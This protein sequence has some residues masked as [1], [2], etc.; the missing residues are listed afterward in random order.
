MTGWKK[1]AGDKLEKSEI[2][3]VGEMNCTHVDFPA[4]IATQRQ[5]GGDPDHS[6]EL[7]A[8][9]LR[10]WRRFPAH[11]AGGGVGGPSISQAAAGGPSPAP[12]AGTPPPP[13]RKAPGTSAHRDPPQAREDPWIRPLPFARPEPPSLPGGACDGEM[14][15]A[16][17]AAA[18]YGGTLAADRLRPLLPQA[19]WSRCAVLLLRWHRDRRPASRARPLPAAGRLGPGAG[20]ENPGARA[21]RRG[22]PERIGARCRRRCRYYDYHPVGDSA[23][24][25][26]QGC[27]GAGPHGSCWSFPGTPRARKGLWTSWKGLGCS[28][29]QDCGMCGLLAPGWHPAVGQTVS[30]SHP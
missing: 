11:L 27:L 13:L 9:E 25:G 5:C 7:R 21:R 6:G 10:A 8:S 20:G 30:E 14:R 29:R 12:G 26:G 16:V 18:G 28:R 19:G 2:N 23:G 15:R 4:S 1:D 3:S 22:S 17:R 24:A